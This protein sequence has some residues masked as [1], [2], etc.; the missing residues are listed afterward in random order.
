MK[1]VMILSIVIAGLLGVAVLSTTAYAASAPQVCLEPFPKDSSLSQVKKELYIKEIKAGIT[2][3]VN[4][5]KQQSPLPRADNWKWDI[6]IVDYQDDINCNIIIKFKDKPEG[7]DSKLTLGTFQRI[8]SVGV[9]NMYYF[10][11]YSC[12]IN[13]DSQYIYYGICRSP[14][15]LATTEE[16]GSI[17]RHEFG[18]AL[19]LGHVNIN[20]S[21]MHP[22]FELISYKGKITTGDVKNVIDMYPNG[23]YFQ[24]KS[25]ESEIIELENPKSIPIIPD[26]IRNTAAWWS[27]GQID[28]ATFIQGIE[29]LIENKIIIIPETQK[30]TTGIQPIPQWIK[31]N[32][33]WWAEGAIDN[34]TFVA[35]L[36]FLIQKGIISIPI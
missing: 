36:E 2:E 17:F 34:E 1:S 11:P 26:W 14:I 10:T 24:K 22:T 25:P 28:D 16:F 21:L 20:T 13:R 8:D 33:G 29:Y 3:W 4:M 12:E 32:A 7:E 31:N 5:L 19:G 35:G 9:I 6:D 18:H 30:D 23:F 27:Y 15:D